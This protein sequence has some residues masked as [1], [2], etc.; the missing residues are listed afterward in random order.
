M[1]TIPVSAVAIAKRTWK[2]VWAGLANGDVGAGISSSILAD[3]TVQVNGTFGAGGTVSIQGSNNGGT[4]WGTVHDPGGTALTLTDGT[5]K[6]CLENPDMIRPS[7]VGDG[8]TSL[9]VTVIATSSA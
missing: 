9:T 2:F 1:A 7:A 6:T 3:K 5:L 4:T 8:S